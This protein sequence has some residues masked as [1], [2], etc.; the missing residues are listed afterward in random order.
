MMSHMAWDSLWPMLTSRMEPQAEARS[1]PPGRLLPRLGCCAIA[2]AAL[3][4][5]NSLRKAKNTLGV[6]AAVLGPAVSMK[7]SSKPVQQSL[8]VSISWCAWQGMF[9]ADCL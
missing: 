3:S 4:L 8:P 9:M 2:A 5:S 1:R 7:N 6:R